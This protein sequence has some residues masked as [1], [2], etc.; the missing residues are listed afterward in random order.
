VQILSTRVGKIRHA[1]PTTYKLFR[2]GIESMQTDDAELR[3]ALLAG[4]S[5]SWRGA[6]RVDMNHKDAAEMHTQKCML[7]SRVAQKT[8]C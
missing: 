2:H 1:S 8:I 4:Q 3:I 6:V 5:V 7:T